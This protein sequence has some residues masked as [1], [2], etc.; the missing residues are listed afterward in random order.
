MMKESLLYKLHR[1]EID[2][3]ANLD[4]SKFEEVYRSKFGKVRIYKIL[5]I[6]EKS[7]SWVEDPQ[8]RICD[9]PGSWLCRGQY[10]P[11][12]NDALAH[13]NLSTL[14][15][16][17]GKETYT[18]HN[19]NNGQNKLVDRVNTKQGSNSQRDKARQRNDNEQ[20]NLS[21]AHIEAVNAVWKDTKE[22]TLLFRVITSGKVSDLKKM[23]KANPVVGHVRSS[24]GR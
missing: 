5:N 17:S 19:L 3:D 7:K 15:H 11:A 12:L 9:E 4:L 1:H 13:K 21:K 6:D 24:D 2:E 14:G 10:P 16:I 20:M 23:I 8:N 18:E 22:T